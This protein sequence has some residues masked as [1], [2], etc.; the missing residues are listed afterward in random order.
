MT[1]V[2]IITPTYNPTK[3][4]FLKSERSI[5]NQTLFDFEWVL[6]DDGSEDYTGWADIHT[7]KNF[8]PSVARNLGFQIA[9]GDIITYLDLGD[10]LSPYRVQSIIR[11]FEEF[12][13]D[14]LFSA[15]YINQRD[16]VYVVNHLANIGS[17]KTPDAFEYLKY[18]QRDNISIPLG[19]A[20]TR[21]PFVKV[22]GFQRGIVCGEDG[23]LWR[24]MCDTLPGNKIM[25][26]D[27]V[28]GTYYVSE[29][30]QSRTQR[31]FEMGGFAFDGSRRDNGQYLDEDWF[32]NFTSK[33]YYE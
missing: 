24:R 29:T 7:Q 2:S 15:Y 18:L 31:R 21:A 9:S 5:A 1:K 22:G 16:M 23:I 28:A 8:G 12:D 26:S 33:G 4:A 14:V 27:E 11:Q 6:V 17:P 19:V 13:I 30:G 20:H 32:K 10:E 3:E 25:F